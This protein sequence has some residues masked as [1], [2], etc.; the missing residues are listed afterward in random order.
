MENEK[1]ENQKISEDKTEKVAG[2][3][4][5]DRVPFFQQTIELGLKDDE[6]SILEKAGYIEKKK[7]TG[8]E[9]IS[10]SKLKEAIDLL[11][12]KGKFEL[13]EGGRFSCIRVKD[14]EED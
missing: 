5:R 10:R 12:K 1:M 2:G 14:P 13:H 4:L 9:Y 6:K 3:Y 7:D 8:S 11:N